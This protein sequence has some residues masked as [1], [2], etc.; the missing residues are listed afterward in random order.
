MKKEEILAQVAAGQL[1][2][3]EASKLLA[4]LETAKSKICS[5]I[6]LSGERP[7]GRLFA[8]EHNWVYRREYCPVEA[9]LQAVAGVSVDQMVAVL[10]KY[11]LS[12]PTTVTIGPLGDVPAPG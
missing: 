4:E 1:A 9:D 6:V 3:D 7:R 8:L 12:R 2:V 11:P 10:A 5:R